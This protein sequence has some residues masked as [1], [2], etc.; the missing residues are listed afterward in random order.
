M[1]YF[2]F[3]SIYLCRSFLSFGTLLQFSHSHA[4]GLNQH[5]KTVSVL[6]QPSVCMCFL[7]AKS[8]SF[9]CYYKNVLHLNKHRLV[10]VRSFDVRLRLFAFFFLHSFVLAAIFFIDF[11]LVFFFVFHNRRSI[12]AFQNWKSVHIFTMN[13]FNWEKLR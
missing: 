1:N 7:F 6:H 5:S 9:T 11:N 2:Y 4:F 12:V 13:V 8:I 10:S 3:V